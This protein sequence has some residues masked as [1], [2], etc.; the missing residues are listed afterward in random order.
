MLGVL[1]CGTSLAYQVFASVSRKVILIVKIPAILPF[2][3]AS[4]HRY[5]TVAEGH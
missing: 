2:P 5:R 4:I 1:R 3:T